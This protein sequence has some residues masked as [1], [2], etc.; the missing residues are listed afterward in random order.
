MRL[1]QCP[2]LQPEAYCLYVFCRT[3][4]EWVQGTSMHSNDAEAGILLP[5]GVPKNS[6]L[7]PTVTV[8]YSTSD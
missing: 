3:T 7:L 8:M 6:N 1:K 2:L 5:L 4:S